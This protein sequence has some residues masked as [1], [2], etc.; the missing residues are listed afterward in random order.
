MA[1]FVED[2]FKNIMV[3][4]TTLQDGILS[5]YAPKEDDVQSV[6]SEVMQLALKRCGV[7]PP[8]CNCLPVLFIP[9]EMDTS[10]LVKGIKEAVVHMCRDKA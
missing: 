6:F 5:A 10:A 1:T 3:L 4:V 7:K 2:M 9:L 8:P